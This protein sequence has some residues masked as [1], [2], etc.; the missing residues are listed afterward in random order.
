MQV[1]EGDQIR[2]DVSAPCHLGLDVMDV[3]SRFAGDGTLAVCFH[4]NFIACRF[5]IPPISMMSCPRCCV[6][7]HHIWVGHWIHAQEWV[8]WLVEAWVLDL[9]LFQAEESMVP[10]LPG[11]ALCIF[12]LDAA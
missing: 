4:P 12:G 1:A 8:E 3:L 11:I 9:Q 6:E 2:C 10:H 5:P 7:V